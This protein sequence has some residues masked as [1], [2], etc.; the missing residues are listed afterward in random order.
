MGL[1]VVVVAMVTVEREEEAGSTDGGSWG[2]A[3]GFRVRDA[4]GVDWEFEVRSVLLLWN[5]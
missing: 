2:G 4:A 5:L 1:V 3:S